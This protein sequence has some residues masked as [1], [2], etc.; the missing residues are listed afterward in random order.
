[1]ISSEIYLH[2]LTFFFT[3]EDARTMDTA[4]LIDLLNRN[5]VE[6]T[7]RRRVADKRTSRDVAA[8]VY[9]IRRIAAD[10][11]NRRVTVPRRLEP[12][13]VSP[14]EELLK[15]IGIVHGPSSEMAWRRI[16]EVMMSQQ[17]A[18]P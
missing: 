4:D 17:K 10:E 1:M 7:L 2:I 11:I 12:I 18:S 14:V 6:A 3:E 15:A 13:S 5:F 16:V 8:E 9:R